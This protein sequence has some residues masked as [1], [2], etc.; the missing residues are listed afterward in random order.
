MEVQGVVTD[1]LTGQPV[2]G[3]TVELRGMVTL[4]D[5][6][7]IFTFYTAQGIDTAQVIAS[8]YEPY[9]HLVPIT[10]S[11]GA[12]SPIHLRPRRLGPVPTRCRVSSEG[13]SAT[14]VDLQGR[15]TAEEWAQG[16]ASLFDPAPPPVTPSSVWQYQ[17]LDSIQARVSFAMAS[18]AT[19][20]SFW[21]LEDAR[22]RLFRGYC[23]VTKVTGTN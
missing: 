7:G 16:Y 10:W 20:N 14:I 22:A 11:T 19:F 9:A 4:T 17:A 23:P 5:G 15:L 3:A 6:N 21:Q 18:T 2:A 1:S 12:G 13:F 8:G